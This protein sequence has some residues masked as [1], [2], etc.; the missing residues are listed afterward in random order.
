[1]Y[2]LYIPANI[3]TG[4]MHSYQSSEYL[5]S[6]VKYIEALHGQSFPIHSNFV[7]A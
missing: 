1:M 3:Y 5:S 6:K 2:R 4:S 7:S